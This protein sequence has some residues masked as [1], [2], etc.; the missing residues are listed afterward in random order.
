MI[1]T[2]VGGLPEVVEDG[3]T[4]YLVPP[5]DPVA[6]ADAI[7][8]FYDAGGRGVFEAGVARAA[9]RFS[10]GKLVDGI[11]RLAGRVRA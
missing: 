8:K 7:L 1:S 6:L 3:V 5:E 9:E 10:W 2:A 11:V 4:G